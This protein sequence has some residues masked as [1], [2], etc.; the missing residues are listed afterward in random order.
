LTTLEFYDAAYPPEA[1]PAGADGVCGY[2]G[3]DALNI[4]SKADWESQ[5][6]RYRLPIFVRA[7]PPGP[8]AAADVAAAVKELRAL[9]APEGTLVA[10]D[11]EAAAD[12]SYIRQVSSLLDDSGYRLI[13]YGS[14]SS[15]RS[16]DNPNGLYWGADWTG[17]PHIA[18]GDVM[19]Q[20]VNHSSY[21]LSE[22]EATLPFWDTHKSPSLMTLMLH[23][24][25]GPVMLLL[26]KGTPTP[27]AIPDGATSIRFTTVFGRAGGTWPAATLSVN[28]HGA[29][30]AVSVT[31]NPQGTWPVLT[32]PAGVKGACIYRED[33]GSQFVSA[34]VFGA[35]GAG[36]TA[37]TGT[38]AA[39]TA[40]ASPASPA[41]TAGTAGTAGTA[42]G[43]AKPKPESF[44][45]HAPV[46]WPKLAKRLLARRK[47]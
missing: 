29:A 14:Q 3:G 39:G 47:S 22:A 18:S 20:W 17:S 15:V 46:E 27:I 35:V 10:W 7:N 41:A 1:P 36:A 40:T 32:I 8:G 31:V 38:T 30:E 12:A 6:A 26:P 5:R 21:D 34:T 4:W 16:N 25:E 19:T 11:L 28:W 43:G 45:H 2:I 13:V 42:A 24:Q 9:G 44:L 33:N 23:D 37:G